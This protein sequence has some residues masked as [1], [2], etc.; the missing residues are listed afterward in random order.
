MAVQ[1]EM[2]LDVYIA[3]KS[4]NQI[5]FFKAGEGPGNDRPNKYKQIG[6]AKIPVEYLGKEPGQG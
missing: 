5:I 6:R 2:E 1:V 3:L 4:G